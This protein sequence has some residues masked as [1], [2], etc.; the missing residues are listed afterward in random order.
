MEFTFRSRWVELNVRTRRM[1]SP[2]HEMFLPPQ[3]AARLGDWL[4]S[5]SKGFRKLGAA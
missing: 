4:W 1:Y 3:I 5:T 2:I